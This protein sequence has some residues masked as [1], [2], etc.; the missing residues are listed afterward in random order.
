MRRTDYDYKYVRCTVA[1]LVGIFCFSWIPVTVGRDL[2]A[3]E[4]LEFSS[5][6]SS[7]QNDS[8]LM[9]EIS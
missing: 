4:I 1:E 5:K 6:S 7:N 8:N 3:T 2:V 9:T